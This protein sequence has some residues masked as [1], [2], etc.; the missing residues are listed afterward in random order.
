MPFVNDRLIFFQSEQAPP[1]QV[2]WILN[3]FFLSFSKNV[4][5]SYRICAWYFNN[6]LKAL[7]IW[8]SYSLI[9]FWPNHFSKKGNLW[10]S[11]HFQSFC[12]TI[13]ICEYCANSYSCIMIDFFCKIQPYNNYVFLTL[14]NSQ[15][16][17]SFFLSK[18]NWNGGNL[19]NHNSIFFN[20]IYILWIF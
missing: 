15:K 18:N 12:F 4:T 20:F 14:T 8:Q 16:K 19:L 17:E 1:G 3:Y 2:F 7:Q 11:Q 6:F 9:Y 10:K 5:F 13:K